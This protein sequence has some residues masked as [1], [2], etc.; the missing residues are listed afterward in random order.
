[1]TDELIVPDYFFGGYALA[2]VLLWIAS[3][4]ERRSAILAAVFHTLCGIT[5]S[6]TTLYWF[7]A[8]MAVS[9][10]AWYGVPL[11]VA[12]L[13]AWR[14]WCQQSWVKRVD[15]TDEPSFGSRYAV[16]D[17]L[18]S[19]IWVLPGLFLIKRTYFPSTP[20]RVRKERKTLTP[21]IS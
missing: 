5:V 7:S 9:P 16:T 14:G 1:M 20:R 6:F 12:A 4:A 19:L 11:V 13:L 8:S 3:W 15:S 17:L 18:G 10:L 21:Q 2:F